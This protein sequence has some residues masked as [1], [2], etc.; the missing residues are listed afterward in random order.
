[1]N[2]KSFLPL[3]KIIS[4]VLFA[5]A[6]VI[7]GAYFL[8]MKFDFDFDIAHFSTDSF[9]FLLFAI[10][11]GV[12]ALLAIVLTLVCPKNATLSSVPAPRPLSLFGGML[13]AIVSVVIFATEI[14]SSRET[15]W[16]TAVF[17]S[18]ARSILS[19]WLHT[20]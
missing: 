18:F 12:A 7:A 17:T 15:P 2:N 1:M 20:F 16:I 13:S 10:A 4:T 11:A 6:A 8:A 19:Q 9:A 5:L 14:K 3:H